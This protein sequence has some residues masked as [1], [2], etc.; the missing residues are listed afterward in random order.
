MLKPNFKNML[1]Y[2]SEKEADAGGEIDEQVQSLVGRLD[3]LDEEPE[4]I[5][6]VKCVRR[7]KLRFNHRNDY[8]QNDIESLAASILVY[9][10]QNIPSGYYDEETETYVLENGERRTRALD[11]LL[12]KFKDYPDKDSTEYKLYEQNVEKYEKGYPFN[13]NDVRESGVERT[14]LDEIDADIRIMDCNI[15][16]RNDQAERLQHIE[17]RKNL[18]KRKKELTG[19]KI[20]INKEISKSLGISE[21]QVQKYDAVSSLIPELK[22]IFEAKDISLNDGAYYAT[23]PDTDQSRIVDL[24]RAG[25]TGSAKEIQGLN[26]ELKRVEL[27]KEESGAKYEKRIKALELENSE[28]EEGVSLLV[29]SVR[30]QAEEEKARIRAEIDDEYRKDKPDPEQVTALQN[31]INDA[32]KKQKAALDA[33]NKEKEKTL[34][35]E[36]EI[37]ELKI[38][39]KQSAAVDTAYAKIKDEITYKKS[40]EEV[41]R[42]TKD[43]LKIATGGNMEIEVVRMNVNKLIEDLDGIKKK[44]QKR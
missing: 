4:P 19:K 17:K 2:G 22:A 29:E 25:E 42:A 14:E 16:N 18:L 3:K 23:L 27:E 37:E 1:F 43:Y 40:F 7:D 33:L 5:I 12:K 28:K 24:L 15:E 32:E 36:E 30:R 10:L 9:K 39:L 13:L 41:E 21:R 26:E 11:Y 8:S 20:N 34:K 35:K 44:L 31:R 38:K 6:N